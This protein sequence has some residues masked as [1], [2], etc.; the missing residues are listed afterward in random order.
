MKMPTTTYLVATMLP[1]LGLACG[2]DISEDWNTAYDDYSGCRDD[3]QPVRVF[4]LE[5][6]VETNAT[7]AFRDITDEMEAEYEALCEQRGYPV[8]AE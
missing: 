3:N 5:F 6:D 7:E 4:V 8:A 1:T 2:G